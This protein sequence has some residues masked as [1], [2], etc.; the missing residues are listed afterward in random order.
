[1][2]IRIGTLVIAIAVPMA[3]AASHQSVAAPVPAGLVA[4]KPLVLATQKQYQ[5][6]HARQYY[7]YD[8]GYQNQPRDPYYGT[9]FE[10]VVPYG[11]RNPYNPYRGTRWYGTVPY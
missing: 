1:M 11:G 2:T 3:F 9:G 7:N 8:P 5:R 10:N 6:R 4:G